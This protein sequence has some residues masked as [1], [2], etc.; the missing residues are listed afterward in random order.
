MRKEVQSGSASN[1]MVPAYL[2]K[3]TWREWFSRSCRRVVCGDISLFF[4]E[5]CHQQKCQSLAADTVQELS[6]WD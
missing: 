2:D 1:A 4:C 3:H 5:P 6:E